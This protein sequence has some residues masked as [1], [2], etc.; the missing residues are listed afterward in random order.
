MAKF[1]INRPIVAMVI[2]IIMVILGIIAMVQLPI[3]QFPNI[4]PPE[5]MLQATYVGADAVT[6]EKSVATPIEQMMSGVDNMLYM[7]SVNANNGQMTLRV[8]FDINTRPNDDQILAQM[9][10]S[11]AESQLP[12]DVRNFGVTIKKSTT[13]PLALFS[14]YSPKGTY[15][16]IFLANYA[17]VNINDP[18]TR[19]PG[20]GQVQIF[21]A[22]Q[23]AMRF[24]VRPDQLAKLGIT[25]TEIVNAIK[26]Q[27]TVNPAGQVGMEPVPR[28]QEFTYSVRAQGRLETEEEFG[29]IVIRANPDGSMV[30][31]KDV[32]RTELGA[33][34]YNMIGRMNGKPS[35]IIAIYQLPGSNAIQT[36]DAATKL[37]EEMKARFPGDL[38]YVTSLD[39]TLAVREGI[40]EIVHTLFE[41]LGL[42]I[43]VVY[44]FLQGWRATLIPLLAVPVSLVG[45][46]MI[47]PLL[48]FSINTL[49]LFGLVLAIGLVVDDAIVVVEAVE[50][51]IEHGLSPKEA[52]LKAMEEVSGPVVAI[53]LIL[54]A[55]FVPT[56]FIPGIT[57]RLY[58][59]F[60]ITIAL[61]VVISAFNAL[62]LSPALSALLLRP[63]KPA[64]GPLGYFFGWF[65]KWFGRATD[66]YV[67]VCGHLIR[68]AGFSMLFLLLVAVV[69]AWL[70]AQLPSGFLPIED[71]GYV[72]L[73]VQL[74]NASSLQRTDQFC[75]Q[76]EAILKETPGVQYTTT[77]VG[78]SLLSTVSTTYNAFFFVTLAPWEERK[79]PDEQLLPIFK[80][81]NKQLAAMPEA[82]AFLFPPP[83]IP[84]VGTSGGV[85]FVLEDRAGR[86]IGFLAD[87]TQKFMEAARKRPEIARID[88]TFIPDV[89]QVFASVDRDKVLKQGMNLSDVYQTLQAFMGGVMVNFFN[90][91]G[92]VWQ[93]YVEAE[94][95]FRTQ[96]ENVGQFYVRNASGDMVPLSALVRMDTFHGPEFTMRYNEYRAAQLVVGS[97]TGYSSGQAMKALEEVFAETMP[98]GMGYDYMGMSFQEK[99]A[100]EGVPAS[101]IF[102]FSLLF[103]FLILAAQYES[104]ALPFS[105]LLGTPVAVFGAFGALWLLKLVAPQASEN[106]VFTQIGLV[107]LIGLAAKNAILIVEFAK[108]EY[109][110]GKSIMDAALAGAKVR[111]R[112]ILMTAF[113]FIFGVLP[114]VFATGAGAHGRVLLGLA[115]FGGMLAAS[116]IAIFLIPVTFYVVERLV[117]GHEQPKPG[118]P[119]PGAPKPS[120]DGEGQPPAPHPKAVPAHAR[121][122]GGH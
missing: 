106:D 30:R 79:K 21:G 11:Q 103:V 22:G 83:A 112:P 46:F 93:V 50:H 15:D 119:K 43:I 26:A 36:M 99:V 101:V 109:E 56:A 73:N 74:P 75:R 6:L 85:S 16:E 42:V 105:V 55:V 58:Q 52:S 14:L 33:Q 76:I 100:A 17:Y 69:S 107:M 18:M 2:S 102:G 111:L 8:N 66:G 1:F 63:K 25:V 97:A 116:V 89:P 80:N 48:G 61:S 65:N 92:R 19:V 29:K 84:G 7:Y 9:R 121:I 118:A 57:G 95:E 53:A 90:R 35:A 27:N 81:V 59:Q 49:S 34:M 72:Y 122:E 98:A 41:A 71:Q 88:T 51:H 96:A 82:K 37:M 91:F 39:T 44:I 3:A 32:A 64:R 5:I 4:A 24:W 23:Y 117:H 13:S 60:A 40:K 114:L 87:N 45:T 70:G 78:F 54:A 28:G 110:G 113:A 108:V 68:K 47:F 77:V 94:G 10:Y 12:S 20:I 31:L 67:R 120:G 115:V 86:D 104:W 38:D 62:T